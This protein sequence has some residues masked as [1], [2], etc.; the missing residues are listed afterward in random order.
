MYVHCTYIVHTVFYF[1]IAFI[2]ISKFVFLNLILTFL[3]SLKMCAKLK[4]LLFVLLQWFNV[5]IVLQYYCTMYYSSR[6][7]SLSLWRKRTQ[8]PTE[9]LKY[10]Y[11]Y[12]CLFGCVKNRKIPFPSCWEENGGRR[13]TLH[14]WGYYYSQI[15]ST[16]T[17]VNNTRAFLSGCSINMNL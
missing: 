6:F 12:L 4:K 7:N 3:L 2:V 16:R 9:S 11:Y 5:N 15:Y 8:H 1:I 13:E 17:A 10:Y 14:R